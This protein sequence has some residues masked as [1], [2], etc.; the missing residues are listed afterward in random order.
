MTSRSEWKH[1]YSSPSSL[2]SSSFSSFALSASQLFVLHAL[3]PLT[4]CCLVQLDGDNEALRG[5]LRAPQE[6]IMYTLVP[7]PDGMDISSIFELDPTTLRGG[8]SMV[9]RYNAQSAPTPDMQHERQSCPVDLR[10][11]GHKVDEGN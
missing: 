9:P 2:L 5:R 6:K 10:P 1:L 4:A 7:V 11:L 8:D 3:L